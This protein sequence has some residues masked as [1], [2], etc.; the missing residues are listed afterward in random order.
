MFGATKIKDRVW[1]TSATPRVSAVF[2]GATLD[3][4][5]DIDRDASV[6]ALALFSGVDVVVPHGW[7]VAIDGTPIFGGFQ[8]KTENDAELP[9]RCAGAERARGPR[10]S[11]ASTPKTRSLRELGPLESTPPGRSSVQ[12]DRD[13]HRL[14]PPVRHADARPTTPTCGRDPRPSTGRCVY[15]M[16]TS[17]S[18]VEHGDKR[19]ASPGREVG[20]VAPADRPGSPRV[21]SGAAMVHRRLRPRALWNPGVARM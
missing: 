6:D 3:L 21:T 17:C 20:R 15:P 13:R 2:G 9:R 14:H 11:A 10:S 19:E 1:S 4:V 7:R 5:G 8:D 12:L 16:I 18:R